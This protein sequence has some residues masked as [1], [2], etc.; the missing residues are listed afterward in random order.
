MPEIIIQI[1]TVVVTVIID[2][3]I[4]HIIQEEIFQEDRLKINKIGNPNYKVIL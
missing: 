3:I 2:H 1:V 4:I